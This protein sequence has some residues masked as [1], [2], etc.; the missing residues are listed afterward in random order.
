MGIIID[1]YNV[2]HCTHILPGPYAMMNPYQLGALL[3][4]SRWRSGKIILVCDGNPPPNPFMEED[5][6]SAQLIFTGKRLD[7]D[8]LIERL[9]EQEDGVRELIVVSNDRRIQRAAKRRKATPLPSEVFLHMLMSDIERGQPGGSE[10]PLEVHDRDEWLKEFE[11]ENEEDLASLMGEVDAQTQ[12]L[13]D[14][15]EDPPQTS[16]PDMSGGKIKIPKDKANPPT[17]FE[18][19]EGTAD[20]WMKEFGFDD[21]EDDPL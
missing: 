5:T 18:P 13:Q 1:G 21:V 11:L 12:D 14:T 19:M 20:Y 17:G 16:P 6:G 9:I 4:Q 15:Q 8:T 7:A 2:L 3:A 10:K